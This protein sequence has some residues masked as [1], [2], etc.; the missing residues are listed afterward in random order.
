M[1]FTTALIPRLV[2]NLWLHP[3][4]SSLRSDMGAYAAAS[5]QLVK[6]PF[7]PHA[8]LNLWPFGT[9]A[10][11]AM[12]QGVAGRAN[13]DA[14]GV[15]WAVLGAA[16]VVLAWDIARRVSQFSWMPAAIA[17]FGVI[18]YPL[19]LQGSFLMSEPPFTFFLLAQAWAAV[20]WVLR[21]TR[22]GAV[23]YGVLAAA[24]IPFRPQL[25]ISIALTAFVVFGA[26]TVRKQAWRQAPLA[27]LPVLG[28]LA[29]SS[30]YLHYNSGRWGIVSH[31][32][33][34]NLVIGRC[35]NHVV[36]WRSNRGRGRFAPVGMT[37]VFGAE[38]KALRQGEWPLIP[39]DPALDR[40]LVM[41]GTPGNRPE[42]LRGW[43]WQ[44]IRTTGVWR[45]LKYS[46]SHVVMLWHQTRQF[47]NSRAPWSV[48]LERGW[49]IAD[50][51]LFE[52]PFFLAM[53]LMASRRLGMRIVVANGLALLLTAAIFFG[54][55]RFRLPYMA[56]IALMA[57]EVWGLAGQTLWTRLRRT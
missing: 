45:Q 14:V 19:I 23:L 26:H 24:G 18:Y 55:V 43:V 33:A 25:L 50:R 5:R 36:E 39:L 37:Q 47:P 3:L 27:A 41:R 9:P 17:V 20:R 21:P 35:H 2:T 51:V 38:K 53:G 48:R 28:M 49:R 57:L 42:V 52:V 15:V 11:A 16:S 44:C 8:I 10:L 6:E 13:W 54:E 29:F 31:N 34:L 46:A 32:S 22:G 12:I 56:L 1:V 7:E 40:V 30:T 4:G